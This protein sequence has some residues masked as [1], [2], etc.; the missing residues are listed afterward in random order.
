MISDM[1]LILGAVHTCAGTAWKC[2]PQ[3]LKSTTIPA[4][5]KQFSEKTQM[6]TIK[7]KVPLHSLY[8]FLNQ[9]SKKITRTCQ[10]KFKMWEN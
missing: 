4:P 3:E 6:Q 10:H 9:L 5:P 7:I 8:S 2:S 1:G